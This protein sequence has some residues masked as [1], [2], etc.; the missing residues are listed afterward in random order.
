MK[1]NVCQLFA[2]PPNSGFV[3]IFGTTHSLDLNIVDIIVIAN[4]LF[5][6][7]GYFFIG[8][9]KCYVRSVRH[10]LNSK[11]QTYTGLRRFDQTL[12][13]MWQ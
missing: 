12:L 7:R 9:S 6:Y 8:G 1:N 10:K 4:Q 3:P 5:L 13:K 2:D 11:K